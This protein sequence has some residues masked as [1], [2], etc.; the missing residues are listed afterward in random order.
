MNN[1]LHIL[2]IDDNPDDRSLTIREL[3][4]ELPDVQV[5]EV[6]DSEDLSKSLEKGIFDLV[7]TDYQL[8]WTDGLKVLQAVKTRY[9]DC[10]VIMFT[11]TGT[12][13]VAVEAMKDGLDDY[14]LKSPRHF[15]R[16]PVAVKACMEKADRRRTQREAEKT[17]Q[18][19]EAFIKNILE[20]VGEGFV[21]ID[22][23]Y[24]IVTANKAFG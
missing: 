2:L 9:P 11:S 6:I 24:R 5:E 16:L 21:V 22:R 1:P 17:L 20:S 3:R 15:I 14:V 10:P 13:E 19:S 18:K 23:D 4:R 8:R 7:I 12:E